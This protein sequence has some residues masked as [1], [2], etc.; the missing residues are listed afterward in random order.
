L[1]VLQFEGIQAVSAAP[2]M[3]VP[4]Q[5]NVGATGAANY[6]IPISVPPGTAGMVPSLSLDYSSQTGDGFVGWQWSLGGLPSITRC[7]R[8]VAQDGVQGGINYDSNDRFCLGGQRLILISGTYGADGSEYRTEI[9]GFSKILAHGTAGSGP[10]WFELHA[11]TGLT[12]EFGNTTDSRALAVGTSTVRLWAVDKITDTK[13]N[14]LTATYT[15]D[16]TNGQIYPTRVDYTGNAGASL[17]TYNSVQFTYST[18][19]SDVTPTY[20]AGSLQQT[21][22]LLTH[23]KT[24]QGANLVL[25]YQLAYRAGTL[26]L[27]S[28]LTS[29]TLC[30]SGGSNCLAPTTFGWQGGSGLP[31]MTGTSIST[32]QGYTLLAGDFTGDGLTDAVSLNNT[33]PSGGVIYS[34]SSGGSFSAASMTATYHYY[35]M[36]VPPCAGRL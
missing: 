8:T 2:A 35:Q 18:S 5:F 33:C 14:Y 15:N 24:Y 21:T 9:E 3:I 10:S 1:V 29:V 22:A 25:D 28:R 4:G 32:T 26:S 23:V 31:T 30:D 36:I 27:H 16:T 11:R 20:Q 6:S 13:G 34:G 7:S 19:R 12:L 17:S